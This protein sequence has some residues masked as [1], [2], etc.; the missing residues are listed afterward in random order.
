MPRLR[1]DSLGIDLIGIY[2]MPA[3]R[4]DALYDQ[5]E[6]GT[7]GA[8]VRTLDRIS[9]ETGPAPFPDLDH[10]VPVAGG[11]ICWHASDVDPETPGPQYD[12]TFTAEIVD[13]P[14]ALPPCTSPDGLLCWELFPSSPNA[15]GCPDTDAL[16]PRIRGYREFLFSPAIHAECVVLP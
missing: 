9:I 10:L 5:F 6:L 12:C 1:L 16:H 4:L 13:A 2:A 7:P 11:S 8:T 3:P 15:D 14:R